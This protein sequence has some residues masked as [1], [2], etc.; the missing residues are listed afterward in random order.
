[1]TPREKKKAIREKIIECYL[2]FGR[3]IIILGY[4]AMG[5]G[6]TE[7]ET[8]QERE[9][10]GEAVGKRQ[11]KREQCVFVC[12]CV[13]MWVCEGK[14]GERASIRESERCPH[15]HHNYFYRAYPI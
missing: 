8:E 2:S 7:T 13:C 10:L 11:R 1:M 6:E 12:M 14:K 9:S 15:G 3:D 4:G 5:W